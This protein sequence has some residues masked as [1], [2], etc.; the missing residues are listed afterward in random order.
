MKRKTAYLWGPLSSL[1]AP[2]VAWLVS[3]GWHVH[4]AVKSSLNLLSLSSLDLPSSARACLET[5]LGGHNAFRAFQDRLKLLE[6]PESPRDTIYDALI[7]CGLPPNYDDAR[8]P[9]APWAADELA[10]IAKQLKGVPVFLISSLWGAIQTDSVVPEELEFERRKATTNW[11]RLCQTYELKLLKGLSQI[12]SNWYFIRMPMLSGATTNGEPFGFTGP[13]ALFREL[14]PQYK[15]SNQSGNSSA[16]SKKLK[17]QKLAYN[18][19]STL[20]FL[21]VDIAVYMF[22]RFLEDEHRPRICNFISTQATLNREWLQHL[23]QSLGLKD[24]LPTIHLEKDSLN[25]P[26]VLRKL[27]IEDVQVKTRNLFEVAGRYQLAPFIFAKEY[28][29]KV[30]YAG[31]EKD[32]GTGQAAIS[33]PF[34]FS[35]RLASYYFEEFVPTQVTDNLLRKATMSGISIGF[36]VKDANGLGWI[37][38]FPHGKALVQRYERGAAKPR[39][40]FS[41]SGQTMTRLIQSKIPLHRALLLRQVEVEGPLFDALRVTQVLNEFLKD[42]PINTAALDVSQDDKMLV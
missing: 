3:K 29:D 15:S 36:M 33:S 1:S 42:H 7:F 32:W 10:H 2:L 19:D 24:I 4:V 5:A 38:S 17:T 40:C 35:P 20:W 30:V 37:L 13:S 14:D 21:P 41:C 12:E 23:A 6:A 25:L 31:R 26:T 8:V 18:P 39:I 22:W 11:E 16:S 27:L 28:F 9:R 34:Q